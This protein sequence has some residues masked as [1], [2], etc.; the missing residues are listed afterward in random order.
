MKAITEQTI[1]SYIRLSSNETQKNFKVQF[2]TAVDKDGNKFSSSQF[3]NFALHAVEILNSKVKNKIL[4]S[5]AD[6]FEANIHTP[7]L[8]FESENIQ[9]QSIGDNIDLR[10]TGNTITKPNFSVCQGYLVLPDSDNFEY[11]T[12]LPAALHSISIPKTTIKVSMATHVLPSSH[13]SLFLQSFLA[14]GKTHRRVLT[15]RKAA[16]SVQT[17][18]SHRD[19]RKLCQE[20][21][22]RALEHKLNVYNNENQRNNLYSKINYNLTSG[23][24]SIKTPLS[25]QSTNNQAHFISFCRSI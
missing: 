13:G 9:T 16:H 10:V 24:L 25:S 14:D 1:C 2:Q 23:F 12:D 7:P 3:S 15:N 22:N 11:Q 20:L 19:T 21:H 18:M 17:N 5:I 4:D 8:E 6:V